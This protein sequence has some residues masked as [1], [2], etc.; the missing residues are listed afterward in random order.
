MK[1][2]GIASAGSA[3]YVLLVAGNFRPPGIF[4]GIRV[5]GMEISK[6]VPSF[7]RFGRYLVLL[8]HKDQT[9][10]CRKCKP[11]RA[12]TYFVLIVKSLGI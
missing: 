7:L 6:P 10:T 12:L 2:S 8:K 11:R 9:P 5:F 1:L 3:L 4:N